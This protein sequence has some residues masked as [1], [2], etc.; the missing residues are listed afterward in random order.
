MYTSVPFPLMPQLGVNSRYQLP[1]MG[2]RS[3]DK[4]SFFQSGNHWYMWNKRSIWETQAQSML[5]NVRLPNRES[6]H[7]GKDSTLYR[8]ITNKIIRS[9]FKLP[10]WVASKINLFLPQSTYNALFYTDLA[11][12]WKNKID[13]T[14]FWYRLDARSRYNRRNGFLTLQVGIFMSRDNLV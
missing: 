6:K 4:A 13:R 10:E 14:F 1:K 3:Q 7:D 12:Q 11:S 2:C 8:N 9:L 5:E